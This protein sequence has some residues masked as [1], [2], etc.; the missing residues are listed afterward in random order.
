MPPCWRWRR[1]WRLAPGLVLSRYVT[2]RGIVRLTLG[3]HERCGAQHPLPRVQRF[4][5]EWQ[6]N[7][8][9]GSTVRKVSR[10][11]WAFDTLNDTLLLALLPSA[12]VPGGARPCCWVCAGR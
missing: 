7:N 4:S 9:A 1:W 10:G 12:M 3:Q 11:M 8:F 6:A 2:F 5:T